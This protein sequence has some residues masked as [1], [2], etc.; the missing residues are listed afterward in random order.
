MTIA[1]FGEYIDP[2]EIQYFIEIDTVA[3]ELGI[4]LTYYDKLVQLLLPVHPPAK[5]YAQYSALDFEPEF[6]ITLGG[7]G[8]ILSA[9]RLVGHRG[10]PILGINLGRL[11]FMAKVDKKIIRLAFQQL[12]NNEH[13]YEKR[14]LLKLESN[15]DIFT[16]FPYALNDMT[17]VKRDTSSMIVVHI[18]IDGEFLNSYWADGVILATPTGSTGYNLSCGGPILIPTASNFIITPI[19]PHNLNVRPLVL[20]DDSIIE[21]NVE[22]RTENFLCTLD[23]R[24][25]MIT[26]ATN[27]KMTKAPFQIKMVNLREVTFLSILRNKLMWGRDS[28]N[29]K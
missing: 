19:A 13:T 5:K 11:G 7:D 27:L 22:G 20:H 8:T 21:I 6:L 9:A 10:I 25:E 29:F 17:V 28:R 3:N 12:L 2:D 15:D 26:A 14:S 24:Y 1:V 23:S 16:V 4:K 18:S